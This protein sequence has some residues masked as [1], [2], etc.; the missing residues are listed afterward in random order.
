MKASCK[1]WHGPR[2]TGRD[3]SFKSL[4]GLD[5]SVSHLAEAVRE[6]NYQITRLSFAEAEVSDGLVPG[7]VAEA[8]CDFAV[9]D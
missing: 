9:T 8:N 4:V 3:R 5:L 6:L 7:R 1:S 2:S